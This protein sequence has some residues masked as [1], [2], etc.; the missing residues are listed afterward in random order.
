MMHKA[1]SSIGAIWPS[2]SPCTVINPILLTW[3]S[4]KVVCQISRSHRT[5]NWRFWPELRVSRLLL[6]FEFTFGFEMMHKAWLSIEA[7]S[8]CFSWSSVKFQQLSWSSV[9]FQQHTAQKNPQF[10]P[11]LSVCRLLV[12][13]EFAD[14]FE[15][16]H[17]AWH[18]IEEVPFFF[19]EVI[20]QISRS[21]AE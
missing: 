14:G 2:L 13:F 18:S 17:K 16:L 19:F 11:E 12:E 4:I 8:Y 3:S 6:Q 5:K 7:V 10:S 21:Q 9:K 1:W 15:M 20:H